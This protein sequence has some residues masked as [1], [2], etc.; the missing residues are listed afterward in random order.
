MLQLQLPQQFLTS[1]QDLRLY[2]PSS[3][4]INQESL[5]YIHDSNNLKNGNLLIVFRVERL[6]QGGS[7]KITGTL[8]SVLGALIVT[9]YTGPAIISSRL[10]SIAPQLLL[11]KSSDLILGGVLMLIDSVLAALFIVTQ[12]RALITT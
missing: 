3:L 1:H 12:V 6:K 2:L 7:A 11:K 9:F 4:G 5:L 10:T 8:V